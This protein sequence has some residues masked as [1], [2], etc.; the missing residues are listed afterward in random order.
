MVRLLGA[1]LLLLLLAWVALQYLIVPRISEARPRLETWASEALGV[2]VR[3]A[4]IEALA[5]GLVPSFEL[6][7]VVLLDA[8]GRESLRLPRVLA[9]V[10]LGSLFRLDF[11]QLY[12][13]QPFLE[14][15]RALD[16]RVYVAG[17]PIIRATSDTDSPA[18]DWFFSQHE[19]VI[20]QATVQL[21]DEQ[22]G[23][24]PLMLTRL[25][26]L[27]RNGVRSH[28]FRVDAALPEG[29]GERLHMVGTF[30]QPLLSTRPGRWTEWQ[31]QAFADFS[32]VD[33]DRKSVV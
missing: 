13:E 11:D 18:A 4:E 19:F 32:R 12:V 1:L 31:G 14:V 23:G 10:S 21:V 2:P 22:A 15:R 3:I 29:W 16:G 25:D 24:E 27:M 28:Q 33:I 6:R 17:L 7:G 26:F 5:G 20:R 9:S 30:R 8:Q